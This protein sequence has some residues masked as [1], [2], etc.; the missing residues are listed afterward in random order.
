MNKLRIIFW[1]T[2]V[3]FLAVFAGSFLVSAQD[4]KAA[5]PTAESVA[6][7]SLVPKKVVTSSEEEA[8]PKEIGA[9]VRAVEVKFAG[10]KTTNES[11]VLANLR[12]KVGEP[13][14]QT[15]SEDDV[16]AVYATG[17]FQNVRIIQEPAVDGIKI[18]VLVQGKPKLKDVVFEGNKV[19]K[20]E[21]LKK[22]IK[23]KI[24]EVV[25]EK[26]VADDAKTVSYR[27]R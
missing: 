7:D 15:Q 6:A 27:P 5:G 23:S 14:T 19:F 22:Q 2:S 17:L 4:E 25:S 12:T 10:P 11:V 20:G 8:K 26:Q 3:F 1:T 13:F 9:I 24:G 21:K 16:R 18:V